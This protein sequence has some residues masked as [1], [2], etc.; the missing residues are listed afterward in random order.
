MSLAAKA[1][2]SPRAAVRTLLTLSLITCVCYMDRVM[3]GA[4]APLIKKEF[5][6]SDAE[7]GMLTGFAFSLCFAVCGIPV[8][9]YAD[10]GSRRLLITICITAWSG[11]TMVC[12]LTNSFWQLFVARF[13]VGAAEAGSSPAAFSLMSDLFPPHRR[14][15]AIGVYQAGTMCGIILGLSAAGWIAAHHG[16]RTA[17]FVL[18]APGLI[19]AVIAW[20]AIAEPERGVSDTA[21][22]KST[23]PE[24]ARIGELFS[25]PAF[26]WL[27]LADGFQA[28]S[29]IG[30]AQWLPMFFIRSHGLPLATIAILFGVAFGVGMLIGQVVGGIWGARLSRRHFATLHVSIWSSVAL[31]PCYLLVLWLP[32]V[33]VAIVMAFIAAFVAATANPSAAAAGQTIIRPPL[34][35]TGQAIINFFVAIVGGGV[36]PLIVGLLS[37]GMEPLFGA[38]SLRWALS[39]VQVLALLAALCFWLSA[40]AINRQYPPVSID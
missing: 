28:F 38:E 15:A 12:G 30:L 36:G 10:R 37:D 14:P 23:G 32:D 33:R 18:G 35:A 6:L 31:V 7:L 11:L 29:I 22:F 4:L 39:I 21:I 40:R 3:P 8:A 17:F 9:R 20:F 27:T 16:W 25:N 5:D 34:R 19:L 13:A 24:K 2:V 1:P 26:R